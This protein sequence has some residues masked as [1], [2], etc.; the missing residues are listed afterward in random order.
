MAS[1]CIPSN[2]LVGFVGDVVESSQ[3]LQPC[4]EVI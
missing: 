1:G 4:A 2:A 3:L